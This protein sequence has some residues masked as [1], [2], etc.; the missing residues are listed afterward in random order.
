MSAAA[1]V[2][3]LSDL[4]RVEKRFVAGFGDGHA[5][6]NFNHHLIRKHWAGILVKY[7]GGKLIVEQTADKWP[8]AL[9]VKGAELYN[10]TIKMRCKA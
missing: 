8:V 3:S 5:S 7:Q 10:A 1:S 4:D 6:I 2:A 9:P